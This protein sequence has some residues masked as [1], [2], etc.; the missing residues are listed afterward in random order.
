MGMGMNERNE[1]L[2]LETARS[3][4]HQRNVNEVTSSS[5][6]AISALRARCNTKLQVALTFAP[7]VA[8]RLIHKDECATAGVWTAGA[9]LSLG[10]SAAPPSPPRGRGPP[11]GEQGGVT[12]TASCGGMFG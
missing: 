8:T 11:E 3:R 1:R 6:P 9:A 7:N 5:G 12:G 4:F 2:T 10:P